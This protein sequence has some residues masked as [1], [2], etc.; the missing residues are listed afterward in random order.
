[1][2]SRTEAPGVPTFRRGLAAQQAG[3]ID[4]AMAAYRRAIAQNPGL[5]PAHFNLG[6]LH[7][8]RREYPEAAIC[9]EG[10]ARLRPTIM[11][12]WIN[13]GAVLEK[14]DRH[15]DAV[16]AYQRAA[17]CAEEDP[18]PAYNTGNALLALG[19][20]AGAAAAFRS[21]IELAPDHGDAQWNLA[22]A[23]LAAGDFEGG[24][25][26]YEWRW[27][28][29]ELEPEHRFPWPL[30]KGEP[31]AARRLLVWREQGLGDE[32]LFATCLRELVAA[33][34]DVTLAATDRLVSLFARAF[35][36]VTVVADG[37]WG[38]RPFD[39]HVPLGSLPRYLRKTRSAFPLDTRFLVPDSAAATRW[40]TRLDKLGPGLKVGICWRSGLVTEERSRSYSPLESWGSIFALPDVHFINLQYDDCA[41]EIAA[42]RKTFGVTIHRWPKENLRDDLESVAGLLWNLDAVVT[43]PTAV[44]SLAGAAGVR[45]FELDNGGDW[46]AHGEERSPWF[47][48][49]R[50][51]RR[52]Y[53]TS[54]WAPCAEQV[55][56]E[57]VRLGGEVMVG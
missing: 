48:S 34:A 10:A 57:L 45:T 25:S 4:E 31:V 43:A 47:P 26:Q 46:T 8:E 39:F 28:K 18:A 14:L 53:G 37:Q 35:P 52:P 29:R 56:R 2:I 55:A 33:G 38:Q 3:R 21:V 5:A 51:V 22:T 24:W 6:Q 9:F 20:F 42:A 50:I 41:A 27:R 23:L 12:A 17:A 19:D 13:L 11:D 7:R 30:W 16:A 54:D 40:A 49:I 1:M 32:L 44:S 15:R 36:G